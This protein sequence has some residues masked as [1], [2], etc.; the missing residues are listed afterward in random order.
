MKEQNVSVKIN[1][2]WRT[3]GKISQSDR[4]YWRLSFRN[5]DELKSWLA[6]QGDWL[7]FSLFD[8]RP[9]DGAAPVK[10]APYVEPDLNDEI[11]FAILMGMAA[12]GIG[13]ALISLGATF[14]A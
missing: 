2:K 3:L 13:A 6:A 5:T 8:P 9:K 10:P 11:P 14:Y 4:G 12:S 1:D 7:N